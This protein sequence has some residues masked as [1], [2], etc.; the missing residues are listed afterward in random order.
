MPIRRH[1]L[2]TA[3]LST[4]YPPKLDSLRDALLF[5]SH[6]QN[7]NV[8]LF[9][10]SF[11]V[12]QF[13]AIARLHRRSC[14]NNLLFPL[15]SLFTHDVCVETNPYNIVSPLDRFAT[16]SAL[17][18]SAA[19]KTASPPKIFAISS[20]HAK[21]HCDLSLVLR[22]VQWR[23]KWVARTLSKLHIA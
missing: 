21:K 6:K 20:A 2:Q 18:N 8:L 10:Y 16:Y 13:N 7:V 22:N 3:F 17:A 15:S 1:P 11:P 19:L 23:D 12:K 9:Y 4:A 14:L 5:V